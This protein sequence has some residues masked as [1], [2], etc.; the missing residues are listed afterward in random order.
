[1]AVDWM[2]DN[3]PV[4]LI[5]YEEGCNAVW[6]N[7]HWV[8]TCPVG[9]AGCTGERCEAVLSF[10]VFSDPVVLPDLSC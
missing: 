4:D 6:L 1:M 2:R 7:G 10:C 3:S 5:V 8:V 9:L